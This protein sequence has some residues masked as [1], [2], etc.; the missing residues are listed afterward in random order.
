MGFR[1]FS[2]GAPVAVGFFG[3]F[4]SSQAFYTLLIPSQ[5]L[6]IPPAR[7]VP[8]DMARTF[9]RSGR[10]YEYGTWRVWERRGT[11]R[12]NAGRKFCW[13]GAAAAAGAC[14]VT[15]GADLLASARRSSVVMAKLLVAKLLMEEKPEPAGWRQC[16]GEAHSRREGRAGQ[17][18]RAA[19]GCPRGPDVRVAGCSSRGVAGGSARSPGFACVGLVIRDV[20]RK[21]VQNTKVARKRGFV[22]LAGVVR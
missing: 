17:A 15:G 1:G 3:L 14:G 13:T 21:G 2:R 8:R 6:L 22:R 10:R 19:R 5:G 18:V 12:C 4:F 7:G 16:S 20:S 11:Q 9:R